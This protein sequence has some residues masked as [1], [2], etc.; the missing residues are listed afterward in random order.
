M[1][2]GPAYL[3]QD[4]INPKIGCDAF[5]GRSAVPGEYDHFDLTFAHLCHRRLRVRFDRV[6]DGDQAN[7]FCRLRNVD[8][9]PPIA[10]RTGRFGF[11]TAER[12]LLSILQQ[13]V[14]QESCSRRRLA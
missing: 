12:K 13:S 10:L 4:A 3:G 14:D 9:G 11:Q 5:G 7:H 8:N 1:P 2:F 6:G